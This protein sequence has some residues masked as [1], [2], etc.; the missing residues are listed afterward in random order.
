MFKLALGTAQ[1]GFNY[2]VANNS[3]QIKFT[4]AKKILQLAK[5][6]NIHL[7]DTAVNYGNSEKII[8]DIGIQNFKV[9]SKLPEIPLNC[10]DIDLWVEETVRSSLKLLKI[11]SLYGL[12]IHKPDTILKKSGRK[13]I[14]ALNKIKSI[15]LVKKIGVSVYDPSE[16]DKI[17]KFEN[18]DIV[19]AP[20]NLLDRRFVKSGCLL[21]LHHQNVEIHTRS[22]FLQGLLLMPRNRIPK[23]F[24]V[25]SNIWDKWSLELKKNNL[26]ATSACLS[27]PLSIP[28][29]DHIIFG[30]DNLTQFNQV[31]NAS[32]LK[33]PKIDLSFM[34]SNDERLIN[35]KNWYK[36]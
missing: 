20:L 7:I 22:V 36:L 13:L 25:W 29:V 34:I 24:N 31:I 2:G 19:Q 33:I 18:F 3:G 5:N 12:L 30:V 35:P 14:N 26:S 32:K 28:E 23:K 8:G 27:Y 4:D 11:Q 17:M 6:E 16:C 10:K 9:V 21:K 1:F 15:G